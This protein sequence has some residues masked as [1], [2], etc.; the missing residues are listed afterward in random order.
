MIKMILRE[1]P[2]QKKP[3]M[4]TNKNVSLVIELLHS[5]RTLLLFLK[6]QIPRSTDKDITYPT[7]REQLNFLH[8]RRNRNQKIRLFRSERRDVW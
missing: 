8:G 6:L 4:S 5:K 2:F 3:T 7:N 1:F